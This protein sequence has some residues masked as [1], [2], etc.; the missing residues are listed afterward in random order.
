MAVKKFNYH[1][2]LQQNEIQNGVDQ[3]L[4]SAPTSPKE[5]QFYWNTATK[6]DMIFNGN[7]W[8]S[9]TAQGKTYTQGDGISISGTV[10]SNAGVRS[11]STGTTNGTISVNTGGT[12]ANVAIR[13]LGGAAYTE[14][15]AYATAAQGALANTAVQ[16]GDLADVAT[17]GAYSDL[18]G[19]PTVDQTYNSTSANAQSGKAVAS[20]ISS[21]ISGVYKPAG[22]I[23]FANRPTLSASIEGYVYNITDSFITTNDFVEGSGKSYPAGTNIVCI[24]TS[25]TTYKW[26]V[27][28]GVVDLSDYQLSAT[29]VTHTASTPVGTATTPVYVD[30]NGVAQA[31]TYSL[32]KTVPAN[33]VFTDTTY[34]FSTGL[35]TNGT[36]I[37]VTGYSSLTKKLVATNPAL[38]VTGGQATWEITNTLNTDECGV[39][40]K[41]VSTNEYVDC[42]YEV[43]ASKITIKINSTSNITAGVYKAIIIG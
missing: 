33:A 40:I 42:Y 28:S 31:C 10:I 17:S 6:E 39:F 25:G 11:I 43:T 16:P 35:T 27:L 29:A 13:G 23:A 5:G 41:E 18:T 21:A 9:R 12:T 26:D 2:N 8:V 30:S 3:N 34:T 36:T 38:T 20:A 37:S 19:T 15:A 1:Q 7:A 14:S 24:N 32:N 22:S 4:P